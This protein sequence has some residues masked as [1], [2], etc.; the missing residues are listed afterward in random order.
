MEEQM[1]TTRGGQCGQR[2]LGGL[3]SLRC[4]VSLGCDVLPILHGLSQH[5]CGLRRGFFTSLASRVRR[6]E[7][8]PV[9]LHASESEC[10]FDGKSEGALLTVSGAVSTSCAA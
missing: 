7:F 5:G 1:V 8:G 9:L 10:G 4:L 2:F 6:P 3:A